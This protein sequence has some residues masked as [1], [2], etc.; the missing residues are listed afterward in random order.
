MLP[1]LLG[2]IIATEHAKLWRGSIKLALIISLLGLAVM[3]VVVGIIFVLFGLYVSLAETMKPWEAGL[4]V[5]GGVVFFATI[6]IV[7][8]AW[9]GRVVSSKANP[10]SEQ[11][12]LGS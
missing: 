1:K 5:G 8:I 6:L 2:D 12:S 3:A 7:I 10:V 9:Q 11:S 4:I